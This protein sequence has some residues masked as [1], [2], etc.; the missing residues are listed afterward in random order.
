[1]IIK[2][3]V[4]SAM[5]VWTSW[6][7]GRFN[8]IMSHTHSMSSH[9]R[10]VVG[11]FQLY[12]TL[13]GPVSHTWSIIGPSSLWNTT[14]FLFQIFDTFTSAVELCILSRGPTVIL[15]SWTHVVFP[16][17][18]QSSWDYKH[19]SL[20]LRILICGSSYIDAPVPF[21]CFQNKSV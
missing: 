3:W 14:V 9:P 12:D 6:W 4:S 18:F 10:M 8:H 16:L 1:M 20:S 21:L 5:C 2:Y 15:N 13:M 17:S 11:S 19:V 7:W